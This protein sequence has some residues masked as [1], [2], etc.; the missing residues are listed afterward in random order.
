MQEGEGRGGHINNVPV[1]DLGHCKKV[2]V[3]A[4]TQIKQQSEAGGQSPE[5]RGQRLEAESICFF[6][7]NETFPSWGGRGGGK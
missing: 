7:I 6:P 3:E 4:A 1:R 5:A 2:E